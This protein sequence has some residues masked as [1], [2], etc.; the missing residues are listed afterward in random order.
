MDVWAWLGPLQRDLAEAGHAHVAQLIDELPY[1]VQDSD[2]RAEAVA[3]EL[4]AA[5]RALG[6]PWLEVYGRHWLLQHRVG[7]NNEGVMALPYAVET[8]ELSHRPDTIDCPQSVCTTQDISMTYE[9]IDRYG[10]AADRETVCLETLQRVD[11]TWNCFDCLHREMCD[12]IADQGRPQEALDVALRSIEQ[13]EAV[14]EEPSPG[15]ISVLARLYN[16]L[17]DPAKAETMCEEQEAEVDD[18]PATTTQ[19][20]RMEWAR[21]LRLQGKLEAAVERLPS[22]DEVLV[23]RTL[24]STWALEVEQLVTALVMDN[25]SDLGATLQTML[26]HSERVGSHRATVEL[27]AVQAKLAASR[28]IRWVAEGALVV[29]ERARKELKVD[30]GASTMM[31]QARHLVLS[32]DDLPSPV[33]L[34]Q[35]TEYVKE[36][37]SAVEQDIHWLRQAVSANPSDATAS[38]FLGLALSRAG[39]N[40]LLLAHFTEASQGVLASDVNLIGLAE[41][42]ISSDLPRSTVDQAIRAAAERLTASSDD[43]QRFIGHRLTAEHCWARD[44]HNG[45]I[46]ACRSAIAVQPD[47]LGTRRLLATALLA[48][49]QFAA[50]A[51]ELSTLEP[52]EEEAGDDT[53][54]LLSTATCIEDWSTVRR[55]ATKIGM[56]IEGSEG[57]IDEEWSVVG[58]VLPG[59]S[60]N[61]SWQA[62]RTGPV[63]ARVVEVSHPSIPTQHFN[64]VV[65][66]DGT[67][68]NLATKEDEGDEWQPIFP[69]I[70]TMRPSTFTSWIVDGP[71]PGDDAWIA[72]RD[73]LRQEGWGCW[74]GTWPG[75]EVTDS[76]NN[77]ETLEGLY[78]FVAAPSADDAKSVYQRVDAAS[79]AWKHRPS[80]KGLAEAANVEVERHDAIIARYG[81]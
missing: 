30:H 56:E 45:T 16:D 46:N 37:D 75:Y 21:A 57:P 53:W 13:M 49:K 40:N 6:N 2:P 52:L 4:I 25:D 7:N 81:L 24:S 38:L 58:V 44:D 68:V 22:A 69:V 43:E 11:A 29:G 35:I 66:F 5:A 23:E 3:P 28:G 62:V 1:L 64:T 51:A 61:S 15:Y 55:L 31:E 71:Y 32:I 20:R 79:S 8:L 41:R 10:Y 12:A 76:E 72:F 19:T 39:Q 18:E 27:A 63:T 60:G 59:M 42:L 67:P 14:D 80:F 78:C 47:A 77:D 65:V 34:D 36:S 54:R 48:E 26:E 17:G 33:P 73:S 74:S 50:A 9:S 70:H